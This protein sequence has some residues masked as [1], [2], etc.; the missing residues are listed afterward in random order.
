M[1]LDTRAMLEEDDRVALTEVG[2]FGYYYGGYLIDLVG[3]VDPATVEWGKANGRPR[4]QSDLEALLRH[5][6]ATHYIQTFGNT[7][8][9]GETMDFVQLREWEVQRSNISGGAMI[10]DTWRLYQLRDIAP[11]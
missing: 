9:T 7:P 10:S 8:V 4:Q 2:V 6:R 5:R 11:Q 1:A 3:L